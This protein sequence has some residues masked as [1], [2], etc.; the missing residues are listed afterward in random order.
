MT[1]T[2]TPNMT[3]TLPLGTHVTLQPEQADVIA[4]LRAENATLRTTL[5]DVSG[6]RDTLRQELDRVLRERAA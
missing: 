1:P 2:N 3:Y 6:Q 5:I 4:A